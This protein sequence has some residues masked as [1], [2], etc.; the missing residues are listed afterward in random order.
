MCARARARVYIYIYV[1][2]C[3]CV[4]VWRSKKAQSKGQEERDHAYIW[5]PKTL[6]SNP[7]D[8]SICQSIDLYIYMCKCVNKPCDDEMPPS[9]LIVLIIS[10]RWFTFHYYK[11][12]N[13]Y[14]FKC[15]FSWFCTIYIALSAMWPS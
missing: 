1:C 6:I 15:F 10:T 7:G 12:S 3:V 4:C 9:T 11:P 5:H 14:D 13:M 8:F 2:V